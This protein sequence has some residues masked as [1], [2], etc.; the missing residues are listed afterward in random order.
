MANVLFKKGTLAQYQA[1]AVKDE[2]T[3]YWLTDVVEL[4]KG[5]VLYG[6]GAEATSMASGL[7]S[8]VDKVK[9]DKLPENGVPGLTAVDASVVLSPGEDETAIGVQLSKVDGNILELREDGLFVGGTAGEAGDGIQMDGNTVSVKLSAV[10]ANGLFA[11][12]SGIGLSLASAASAGAMSA[13]DK[14]ALDSVVEAVTW[15]DI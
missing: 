10:D 4:W 8:A 14:N 12:G 7:M 2:N 5:N 3:L 13:D 1:L 15:G 6:K 9:L 11:D